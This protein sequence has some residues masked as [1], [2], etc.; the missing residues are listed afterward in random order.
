[1]VRLGELLA[2]IPE[3]KLAPGFT[4]KI[5]PRGAEALASLPLKWSAQAALTI[6]VGGFRSER[7]R[8]RRIRRGAAVRAG[9]PGGINVYAAQ[10]GGEQI[11]EPR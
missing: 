11:P 8:A 9:E 3:F 5:D 10:F 7:V 2:R 4:P 6:E 1:V